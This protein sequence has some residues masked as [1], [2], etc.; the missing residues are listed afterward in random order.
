MKPKAIFGR[1][2]FILVVLGFFAL[3][4]FR[5]PAA[6]AVTNTTEEQEAQSILDTADRAAST[7]DRAQARAWMLA[8]LGA[9]WN[10]TDQTQAQTVLEEASVSVQQAR[11]N[12]EALW[13]QSLSVQETAIGVSIDM[14]KAGLIATDLNAVRAR[15]WSVPLIAVELNKV[16]PVR[17]AEILQAEQTFLESQTGMYRDLQLRGVAQA[18]AV[19]EP[20]EAAATAGAIH[21]ASIRAWTLRE[22]AIIMKDE[23]IFD[24]AVEAARE[25]EDPVQHAR[26]LR[27]V[28]VAS[29]DRDLF[30]EALAALGETTG[31]PL[32]YALSDLAAASGD[33]SLIEQIDPAYADAQTSALLRL[34]EYQAA[35]DISSNISDPYEQARAQ[36]LI[37]RA[38][39]NADVAMKVRVPLYRNLALRDVIR[40]TGNPAL[41]DSIQSAYYQVQALTALGDYEKAVESAGEL[42]DS[43]PLVELASALA[44]DN[45]QA[46]LELAEKMTREA[47]KA[48]VLKTVAAVT[49]D[50]SLFEQAQGMALAARVQ[51]DALAPS[52]ASLDLANL[53]WQINADNA[54]A[55]L[56]QAY[57]AALRISTK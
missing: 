15:A 46:A 23:S 29:G 10:E 56:R 57:E 6:E 43:Y 40:I 35:W 34:G 30:N 20:S 26:A 55:A 9:V 21:D 27:E 22:M 7:A 54:E 25:V 1:A 32:A 28:A 49:K 19:I 31:V 11:K 42:G 18:W 2:V 44:K 12:E 39:A 4:I 53:F 5:V 51:G 37:A 3:P 14:E 41:T 38:W 45:P 33:G 52:E 13:G 48:V 47:D 17:A 24:L 50:Q 16:D 8:H 36:A